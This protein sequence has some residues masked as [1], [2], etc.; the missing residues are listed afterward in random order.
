[1]L[2]KIFNNQIVE[3]L[4]SV[5]PISGINNTIEIVSNIP[6]NSVVFIEIDGFKETMTLP[7]YISREELDGNV[8]SG[9]ILFTNAQ[10]DYIKSNPK[11]VYTGK[12]II[13]NTHI[14]GDF[15]MTINPQHVDYLSKTVNNY[16]PLITEISKLRAEIYKFQKSAQVTSSLNIPEDL[17]AGTVPVATGVGNQYSWDYPLSNVET[18]LKQLSEIVKELS[19]ANQQLTNEVSVLKQHVLDHIYEEYDI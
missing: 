9:Q 15:Y 3:G 1:M 7:L 2:F 4:K 10:V 5:M 13:N 12:F 17:R 14:D 6:M 18:K 8:F 11:Q 19:A 16:I